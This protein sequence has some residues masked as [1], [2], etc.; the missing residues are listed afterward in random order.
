MKGH[1]IILINVES[2]IGKDNVSSF[3]DLFEVR[4][5][6]VIELLWVLEL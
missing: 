6:R 5:F 3:D 4:V 2:I 1:Q